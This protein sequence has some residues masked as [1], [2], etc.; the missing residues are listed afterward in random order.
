MFKMRAKDFSGPEKSPINASACYLTKVNIAPN[1]V[2]ATKNPNNAHRFNAVLS[3]MHVRHSVC[4]N[5]LKSALILELLK[6]SH[7]V[8]DHKI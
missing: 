3:A 4:L 5:S 2:T 7:L 6:K 8:L 1:F